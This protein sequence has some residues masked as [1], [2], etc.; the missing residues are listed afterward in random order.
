MA[1]DGDEKAS[2]LKGYVRGKVWVCKLQSVIAG[3]W[4]PQSVEYK[5]KVAAKFNR[6]EWLE[7]RESGVCPGCFSLLGYE[8]S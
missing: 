8:V 4:C 5:S 3:V 7:G 6:E 1:G 2:D